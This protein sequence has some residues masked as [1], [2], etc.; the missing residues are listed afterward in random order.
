[1]SRPPSGQAILF[2]GPLELCTVGGLKKIPPVLEYLLNSVRDWPTRCPFYTVSQ[3]HRNCTTNPLY[4]KSGE[5]WPLVNE[6]E[7]AWV[8]VEGSDRAFISNLNLSPLILVRL[9]RYIITGNSKTLQEYFW[10]LPKPVLSDDDIAMA[11]KRPHNPPNLIWDTW[12]KDPIKA[13][14]LRALFSCEVRFGRDA[15][16][17]RDIAGA[18]TQRWVCLR[19]LYLLRVEE[20]HC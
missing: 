13:A 7:Q 6:L 1:M 15:S 5:H 14:V 8:G 4:R 2:G 3:K 11:L 12:S 10:A 16:F 20:V 18:L 17:G 19:H 9:L